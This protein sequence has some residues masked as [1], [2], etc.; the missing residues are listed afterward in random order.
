MTF[1]TPIMIFC[2]DIMTFRKQGY[3]IPLP[4]THYFKKFIQIMEIAVVQ[5]KVT[6]R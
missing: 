1:R 2:K 4:I 3:E 6:R 5:K